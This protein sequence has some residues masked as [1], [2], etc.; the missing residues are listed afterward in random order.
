LS[1][2]TAIKP[3]K[4]QTPQEEAQLEAKSEVFDKLNQLHAHV[5]SGY[6]FS[7]S[8]MND[9]FMPIESVSRPP[10]HD[11]QQREEERRKRLPLI[12]RLA[13]NQFTL[14]AIVVSADPNA[15]SALVNS[16]GR[17]FILHRGTLIGPNNGY[18][19]EI[20]ATKVV[21]EE[22]EVNYRGETKYR[23]TVMR[24]ENAGPDDEETFHNTADKNWSDQ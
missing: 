23:E 11:S 9:P 8:V 1:G 7:T 6:V 19:K 5:M 12:Q 15:T 20:T 22:P 4:P 18:V 16:S 24:L 13:I 14:S 10:D 2:T 3:A 21:I 17:G